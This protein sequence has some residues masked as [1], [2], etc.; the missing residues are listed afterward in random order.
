PRIDQLEAVA[1]RRSTRPAGYDGIEREQR[2]GV[3][4][5]D[6]DRRGVAR[7]DRSRLCRLPEADRAET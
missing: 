5:R 1:W 7:D 4:L 3:L 6:P 2:G